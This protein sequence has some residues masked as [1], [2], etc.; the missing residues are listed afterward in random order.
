MYRFIMR[1]CEK[2]EGFEEEC[3]GDAYGDE[4][5]SFD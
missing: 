3:Y 1:L 4:Y 2:F 5:G